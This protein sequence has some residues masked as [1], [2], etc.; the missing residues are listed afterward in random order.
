[1]KV[2]FVVGVML[3][4]V[5]GLSHGSSVIYQFVES[6]TGAIR[7][8]LEFLGIDE[9]GYASATSGWTAPLGSSFS[10][11]LKGGISGFRLDFG[12][13]DF[14]PA[15]LGD[16]DIVNSPL[17]SFDGSCLDVLDGSGSFDFGGDRYVYFLGLSDYFGQ[18]Y[19]EGHVGG[20]NFWYLWG[21]WVL[22]SPSPAIPEPST[23]VLFGVG[24]LG[25]VGYGW[26]RWKQNRKEK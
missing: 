21:D 9:G 8:E 19:M 14:D 20:G 3:L 10:S 15:L 13:G 6:G 18:D 23:L 1:M 26:R 24:F 17:E 22:Q 4:L 12:S 2:L 16:Y 25:L 7:G 11:I 5:A